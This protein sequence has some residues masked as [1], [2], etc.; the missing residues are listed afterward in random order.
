MEPEKQTA[1]EGSSATG[2]AQDTGEDF[3]VDSLD[4]LTARIQ[5]NPSKAANVIRRLRQRDASRRA[6]EQ[7]K[8]ALE[9]QLASL[10][11]VSND[12]A[13]AKLAAE[14]QGVQQQS[15]IV[16]LQ[17]QVE[18]LTA[19]KT[20]VEKMVNDRIAAIDEQRRKRIPD[21]GDS[22]KTLSWIE[23]N[24]D[25]LQVRQPA[26]DLDQGAKGSG[27]ATIDAAKAEQSRADVQTFL[28]SRF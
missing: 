17:K 14:Q 18:A 2:P 7:E 1:A 23:A 4:E 13:Q 19:Y 8:S 27:V 24:A 11:K 16:D 12:T 28:R 26:P 21:F 22:I 25:L 20:A 3:S 6:L 10:A 9:A 15:Q 5:S